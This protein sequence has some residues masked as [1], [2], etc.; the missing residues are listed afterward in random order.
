[1]L[2]TSLALNPSS[3]VFTTANWSSPQ[4]VIVTAVDDSLT[5]PAASVRVVGAIVASTDRA[6]YGT[7]ASRGQLWSNGV[8][9]PANDWVDVVTV[10]QAESPLTLTEG[11]AGAVFSVRLP[12]R[13]HRAVALS[14]RPSPGLSESQLHVEPSVVTFSP[15]EWDTW[16][17]VTVKA[18]DDRVAEVVTQDVSVLVSLLAGETLDPVFSSQ[19][20]DSA[21]V[22]PLVLSDND[23]PGFALQPL[24]PT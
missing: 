14:L 13:P 8:T 4:R 19:G 21:T 23:I 9:I 15:E 18:V 3:V 17:T 5:E 20:V 10:N 24:R 1:L 7:L 22:L 6:S 12:T 11:L 16:R 2:G